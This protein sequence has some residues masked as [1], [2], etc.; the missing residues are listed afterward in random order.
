M[1]PASQARNEIFGGLVSAAVA[2]P[3]AMGY[4]MF[5]LS[6]LGE[7]YFADGALAGLATAFVVAIICVVLG[8]RTTTVYAPRINTTFFLGILI[9]GLVHSDSAAIAAGGTPFILAIAFAVMLLGGVLEA[10]FGVVKLGTLIKFAPQPVM[11]GFQNAAA[12]LLFLVQIGNVCGF[13]HNVPFTDVPQHLAGIRPLSLAIAAITFA[14]MWN[15][16]KF[17]PRI[18][19]IIVAI[20]LGSALYFLCKL[21]GLGAYLGPVI[22]SASRPTMGFTAFDYF[23]GIA[24]GGDFLEFMPTIL[25]GALALA[26]IASIDALLCAKLVTAPGEPRRDGDRLLFR[27]GAGNVAAACIGGI[28]GGINIG[29]SITNRAF[30]GRRSLSVLI[31][32]AVMFVAGA[33]LFRWLGQMPRAVLS[34][35]IMVVA[36]QHFDVWSLRL[37]GELRKGPISNRYHVALDLAVV[38]VVAVLSITVNIALAVFVGV[39]IAIALFVLRMSESVIRRSYRCGAIHSRRS[40]LAPEQIFLEEAGEA[41]LVMELQGAL[42]FGTGEKMLSAVEAE[43]RHATSC[44]ILDLRR[45]T[46]IDSTG[47]NAVLELKTSLAQQEKEFLLALADGTAAMERLEHF[48]VLR[49]LGAAN[50]LPDID[51]AIERAENDLLRAQAQPHRDEIPLAEA[52]VFAKLNPADLAAVEPYLQRASY[53]QNEVI[54]REGD[55]GSEV[56]IVTKG[57]ASAFLQSSRVN[58]RLGTFAP[59]T[60]FGELAILDAGPRSATVIA[61]EDLACFVL[62]AVNFAALTVKHPDVATRVL[63]A[64]GRELSGRLRTAN[65]T[66]H[67]LET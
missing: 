66:I 37:A 61:D 27:L 60:L 8:D 43:L 52:G 51:R 24:R 65:R 47:A 28:T 25:G 10:L 55:A 32:A 30:G 41:I 15:A 33:F 44:V 48:G 34:A 23:H 46:D 59:G 40:R 58:I 49:S 17:L 26:I 21:V 13:D 3:L 57:T 36:I 56:F 38:I 5:A 20:A 63:A 18:P 29:A 35:V 12:A 22:T 16:G 39:A 64:I 7:Y 6:A 67:Q 19:P 4:G 45:L 2:I 62:T 11:A 54:F 14:T 31:S 9:Y 53:R 42:F 50:V 1:K